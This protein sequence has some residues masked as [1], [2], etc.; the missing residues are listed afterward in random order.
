MTGSTRAARYC[1]QFPERAPG[2]RGRVPRL[3]PEPAHGM[4]EVPEHAPK[5]RQAE[6]GFNPG[7]GFLFRFLRWKS[8]RLPDRAPRGDD[9]DACQ[10]EG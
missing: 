3:L 10:N 8:G 9:R 2:C 5:C 1:I 6:P 7:S 4:T